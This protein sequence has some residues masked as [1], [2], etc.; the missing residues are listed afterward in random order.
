MINYNTN[1]GYVVYVGNNYTK[2]HCLDCPSFASS[3]SRYN[4]RRYFPTYFDYFPPNWFGPYA[5]YSDAYFVALS[6]GK[7]YPPDNC[8]LCKP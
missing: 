7:H 2:I 8:G 3:V 5:Q 4:R 6:F 1:Y